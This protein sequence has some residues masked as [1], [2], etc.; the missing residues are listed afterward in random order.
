[1]AR[2]RGI[3]VGLHVQVQTG[4]DELGNPIYEDT[5]EEVDNVLVGEPSTDDVRSAVDMYGKRL[6]YTLAVPKGDTHTWTDTLVDI[7]GDT[8]A[9]FGDVTQGIEALIPLGW[10][11]KVKVE[12]HG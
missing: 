3:T 12:R 11:R 7:W 5:I 9:T 4:T 6:A 10:N 2:L 1:M 8:F